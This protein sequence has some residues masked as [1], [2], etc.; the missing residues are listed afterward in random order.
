M[1]RAMQ[2]WGMTGYQKK[3]DSCILQAMHAASWLAGALYLVTPFNLFW[4][5]GNGSL[6]YNLLITLVLALMGIAMVVTSTRRISKFVHDL[7]AP[8]CGRVAMAICAVHLMVVV[9]CL[10]AL[11]FK[12][13]SW[14]AVGALLLATLWLAVLLLYL[15]RVNNKL[16][17][18]RRSLRSWLVHRWQCN[19]AFW[20]C[21]F[22]LLATRDIYTVWSLEGL[23]YFEL[24]SASLGR[25]ATQGVFT[26]GLMITYHVLCNLTPAYFRIVVTGLFA[27]LPCLIVVDFLIR[28]FWNQSLL[29]VVNFFTA[30]G[31][32]DFY[33]EVAAA[34]LNWTFGQVAW[35]FAGIFL[36]CMAVFWAF[37]KISR[38]AGMRIANLRLII[39]L[40]ACWLVAVTESALSHVTKR[41]E[42][43]RKHHKVFDAHVG[44]FA[45]PAGFEKLEVVFREPAPEDDR[46]RLLSELKDK[47]HLRKPDIYV[48]MV[49]SWRS[50]SITPEVA[51]FLS[52][53]G[54]EE[55]QDLGRTFSGS[56]CTPLSWFSFFH[57]RLAIHWAEA[58]KSSDDHAGAYPVRVLDKLGYEIHVRAVC[59]L[60]YKSLGPLNFG[61]DNHLADF[62]A[63]DS[64]RVEPMNIP[65]REKRLMNELRHYL[66]S[67]PEG[68]QFHFV[69]LDS[70]H[71]NYYWPS[72]FDALHPNCAGNIP[73]NLR[74]NQ[75]VV[76]GV[77]RRYQNAV[78]WVDYA[79]EE[80]IDFLK[81]KGRY[82]NAL[83]VLTGDHGEEFQEDGSWFHCSSLNRFQTEVPIMIK[84]P[85]WAGALPAHDTVSHYDVM[86]S[87]LDLIGLE[88]RFYE[89][90][91]GQSLLRYREDPREVVIS[92]VHRG[93][94]GIGLC[95]V[96]GERKV[97]FSFAGPWSMKVPDRLYVSEYTDV[98]DQPLDFRPEIG[99]RSHVEYIR[100]QFPGA[101]G[102]F[103]DR[104][105]KN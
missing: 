3:S 73:T 34:G 85:Q 71:Y 40:V 24:A 84:W 46:E 61:K 69:A 43:W 36:A 2:E 87:I 96:R 64:K 7:D 13:P 56:N 5:L 79:I 4:K 37:G 54:R 104:M 97:K 11:Y 39:I 9:A 16:P 70:P 8:I 74:P 91:S 78:H 23:N 41:T 29:S 93:E 17:G 51:P 86:P 31:A 65:Q 99:D 35:T 101:S 63:D 105:E 21:I 28:E 52:R 42:S 103:F 88:P 55:A 94:T 81:L 92:T 60:G 20:L 47:P 10:G 102:R 38:A 33:R 27:L 30:T 98:M 49:E 32:F 19:G 90:L 50:D 57:S 76:N 18:S 6:G 12:L 72:D 68:P 100:E 59:D 80:F 22:V 44:M 48:F 66:D 26:L 62:F 89:S 58:L 75:D 14:V 83:I 53:F 77:V 67:D 25:I 15:P 95:L 45:P 82:D 1:K